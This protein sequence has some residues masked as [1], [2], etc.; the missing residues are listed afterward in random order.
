MDAQGSGRDHAQREESLVYGV[1]YQGS[2]QTKEYPRGEQHDAAEGMEE[3]EGDRG[4]IGDT[5]RKFRGKPPKQ[6]VQ[7]PSLSS[8][9]FGKLQ[10]AVQDISSEIGKRIDGKSQNNPE[11]AGVQAYDSMHTSTS[12]RYG[13]FATPRSG[14]QT[15]WYV[16]GC[17]YFWAVSEALEQAKQSV[18]ILDC[19][20]AEN[21][22]TSMTVVRLASLFMALHR[23]MFIPSSFRRGSPFQLGFRRQAFAN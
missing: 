3:P 12:H 9:I 11:H 17:A 4:I 18:W 16:D 6:P 7:D 14:N 13:S 21:L 5:Y 1:D 10:G 20:Y 23:Y 15:K 8:F 2:Y 22:C 19:E